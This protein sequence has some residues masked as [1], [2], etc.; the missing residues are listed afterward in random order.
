MYLILKITS[1]T[2]PYGGLFLREKIFTNQK[3]FVK[4]LPSKCL[5][6]N[7]YSLKSVT[8]RENFPLENNRL[9]DIK[10]SL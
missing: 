10:C 3:Q 8:I 4:I 9:Y 6:F 1:Y 2:I 7:R 5:L